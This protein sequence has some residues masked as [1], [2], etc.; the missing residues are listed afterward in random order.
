MRCSPCTKI[1]AQKQHEQPPSVQCT[2]GR[3][4]KPRPIFFS[5][6]AVSAEGSSVHPKLS[7]EAMQELKLLAG[8]RNQT[9]TAVAEDILHRALLGESHAI[10]LAVDQAMRAGVFGKNR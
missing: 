7:D 10:K 9:L 3:R 4:G 6:G 5:G 1:V 2:F 8:S